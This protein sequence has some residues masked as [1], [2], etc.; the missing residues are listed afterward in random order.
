MKNQT[1]LMTLWRKTQQPGSIATLVRG[2]STALL[3][4]TLSVG[5]IYLTQVL[6]ARW[7]GASA[8]GTYEYVGTVG[9]LLGFLSG[10]GL[11][12]AALRFVSEYTVQQNWSH[13]RGIIWGSWAQTLIVSLV[14]ASIGSWVI[15]RF[16]SSL[17]YSTA[18]LWGMG[19]IPLV[20]MMRL[21]LEMARGAQRIALAYMPSLLLHPILFLVGAF[22]WV[23][24]GRSLTS[25]N[26]IAL[27]II[28]LFIVLFLQLILFH[29][30][31]SLEVK[32][33]PPTFAFR[34]WLLVSLP[35]LF[36][37]G[38]F[39][40]LN[41]TDT[42]MIGTFL[43][44]EAVGIY[45]A[46]SKTAAWVSFIL[47]AV[48]AIAAPMFSS[49]YAQGDRNELQRL[50]ST[51]A[52]WMFYPA[53]AVALGLALFADPVLQWFGSEFGAAKWALMVLIL[54]QLVNVGAGSVGYLLMMTGH[55]Y[56]C[57]RV[58]GCCAILNVVLNWIG[59]P[60][61]GVL[62]AA[63]ATALSMSL[64]NIWLNRMVVKHLGINPS[65]ASALW[66][67]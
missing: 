19:L 13:L 29:R 1:R 15:L 44:T 49:L 59:I 12:S 36:V 28:V 52:R 63:I 32:Q 41:Q 48:N 43:D 23:Q 7:M 24:S 53:L 39:L 51:I 2:A 34:Q 65:I 10:L 62:G 37:D 40:I 38:S 45:S 9:V 50:V 67:N 14:I 22:I 47:A 20:A 25:V 61:F 31:L 42:L 6:L 35:L 3:T 56:Q 66:K 60:W 16:Y 33:A 17:E 11:S 58:V 18:L 30:T 57:A 64:W 8:Y 21:Q 5:V 27:S 4:Q 54:G 55:H 26:A 46:A